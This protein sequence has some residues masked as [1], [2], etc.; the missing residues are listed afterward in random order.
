MQKYPALYI[1]DHD[2]KKTLQ[3]WQ[4]QPSMIVSHASWQIWL[5]KVTSFELTH[6][7]FLNHVKSFHLTKTESRE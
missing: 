4:F 3:Y 5:G 6:S 1:P 2:Y 7:D